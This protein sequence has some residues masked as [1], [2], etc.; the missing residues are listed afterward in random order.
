MS[1][2]N[3]LI[4]AR[5]CV[6]NVG[7]HIVFTVKYRKKILTGKVATRLKEILHQVAQDKEFII[8]T[9][10]LMPD[11]LHLFVTAHPKIAPSYIVKMSK[12]ISGRLLLKEF[13]KLRKQLYKG[14]L[15]NKSYYLETVGNISKDTVK[16]YIENQKS[17]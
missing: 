8:E 4:H 16:Q 14:H 5:T 13:P 7:Y 15:W 2:Q 17:K 11:H 3:N 1:N 6:Y 9:M 10:E 12:G